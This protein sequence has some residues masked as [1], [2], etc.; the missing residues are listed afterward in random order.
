MG[1][2]ITLDDGINTYKYELPKEPSDEKDVLFYDMP[3]KEQYWRRQG[4]PINYRDLSKAQREQY[5]IDE[6]QR[7]FVD[8]KWVFINGEPTWIPPNLWFH[9]NW[10]YIG[11][12]NIIG[13]YPEYR[14]KR[15]DHSY[16]KHFVRNNSN[17][18]GTYTIKNR[19]DGETAMA[20]SDMLWE[21]LITEIGFFGI[22]SKTGTDA[23][24]ACWA[25]LINGFKRLPKV[26]KP[27]M[28]G[29][30]DPQKRLQFK[31]P[32]KRVNSKIILPDDGSEFDVE[33]AQSVVLTWAATKFNAFDGRELRRVVIDEFNKWE[34]DSALKAYFCYKECV[35]L[36][37]ERRGLFDI[38]SSPAEKNGPNNDDAFDF[39]KMCD[40]ATIS[41]TGTTASRIARWFSNPLKGINGFYD[42]YGEANPDRIYEHIM[43]ERNSK[44]K[45][46]RNEEVRKYPL[47]IEEAF[48]T[49]DN[50]GV[51]S[52][53]EGLRERKIYLLGT[54]YKDQETKDPKYII[55]NL[56]WADSIPDTELRFRASPDQS[57]LDEKH[58]RFAV[59]YV[60]PD[61]SIK[62]PTNRRKPKNPENVLGV[63][64]IDYDKKYLG[65]DLSKGAAINI[66]FLD[67]SRT[68]IKM[69][70][71]LL[72]FARPSKAEVFFEDM[73][74][75]SVWNQA[76]V[77]CENKNKNMIKY[78]DDR[79]YFDWLLPS[80][81]DGD[82][83]Q[84]GNAPNGRS[85]F[86]DEVLA[87]LESHID[88][89]VLETEQYN[90]L[91]HWFEWLIDQLI[92]FDPNNTQKFDLVM[93]LGQALFGVN[94]IMRRLLKKGNKR[95]L[96][97]AA[98][99]IFND[100]PMRSM[101]Q[102]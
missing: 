56:E 5:K 29:S 43:R 60:P 47:S 18:L 59:A 90:L 9:L 71:T 95:N 81:M 28:S 78:F 65:S 54:K 30:D 26:W 17:F 39:W 21:S 33:E 68:G 87:L 57:Q 66:K 77:Q 50:A 1:R 45:A 67:L 11:N 100:S 91:F 94:K 51:W 82:P 16:L 86:F 41:T 70:P 22:Q 32:A 80:D 58:G 36:G 53:F 62:A 97:G 79:G 4:P 3:K 52:N 85:G 98:R 93:A 99:Y 8:G 92:R 42:K 38:F 63:D 7:C 61:Y 20:M 31:P 64:N 12:P 55:G 75:A 69:V 40:P 102:G 27:E 83:D 73:I 15:L 10:F 49:Y 101:V 88:K 19:R 2:I 76:M 84:K 48:G 14:R 44:P 72:Y 89:P 46:L 25:M 13:G 37:N 24:E 34:E 6:Y 74:K 35:M 96:K 23:Y